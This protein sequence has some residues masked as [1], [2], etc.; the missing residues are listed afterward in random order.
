MI[1]KT[2]LQAI[3]AMSLLAELPEGTYE[4]AGAIAEKIGA[5]GNYLGKL[6]QAFT[7][8]GL[9]ISQKGLGGGFRLAKR[10]ED[11]SLFDIV[12]PIEQVSRWQ[13]CFM[14]RPKCSGDHP[15]AVHNRWKEV[16]DSYLEFLRETSV[17]DLLAGEPIPVLG[18]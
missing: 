10:P 16:R 8:E 11:I 3:R 4:G 6:L 18:L 14:G 9:V 2:A 15:C 5:R 13:G 17:A 12:D 7:H 1:S